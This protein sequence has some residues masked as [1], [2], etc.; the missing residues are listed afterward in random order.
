MRYTIYT[1]LIISVIT[2]LAIIQDMKAKRTSSADETPAYVYRRGK[3]S[4]LP[5][6]GVVATYDDVGCYQHTA[7][8][9]TAV[10][11]VIRHRTADTS[12]H[13]A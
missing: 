6:T 7:S 8:R 5:G 1:N 10:S 2:N 9:H 13:T 11:C 4:V 3:L 12:H